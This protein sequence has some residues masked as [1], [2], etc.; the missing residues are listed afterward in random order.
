MANRQGSTGLYSNKEVSIAVQHVHEE[1]YRD[2]VTKT[3]S[4]GSMSYN[5]V[6]DDR[7]YQFDISKLSPVTILKEMYILQKVDNFLRR[8][9]AW[10]SLAVLLLE[11]ARLVMT[12][13][14]IGYSL[15]Q[16][17]ILGAKA[18]CYSL[19]CTKIYSTQ[20]HLERAKRRRLRSQEDD[21]EMRSLKDERGVN[22]SEM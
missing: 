10:L 9:G 18:I 22:T 6:F 14:M 16:D 7:D 20:S 17:G 19:L 5:G 4:Y 2:A 15:I 21:A 13:A 1:D 11:I 3:I 8:W 12:L